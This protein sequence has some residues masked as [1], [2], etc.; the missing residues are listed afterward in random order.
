VIRS[1][2]LWIPRDQTLCCPFSSHEKRYRDQEKLEKEML[3]E[4]VIFAL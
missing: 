4:R 1:S 2:V 3:T